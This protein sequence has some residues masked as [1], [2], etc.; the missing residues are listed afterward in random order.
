MKR[1]TRIYIFLLLCVCAGA[2]RRGTLTQAQNVAAG[3]AVRQLDRVRV[4]VSVKSPRNEYDL[5]LDTSRRAVA[6]L[7]PQLPDGPLKQEINGAL[8]AYQDAGQVWAQQDGATQKNKD[9]SAIWAK[10]DLT[11]RLAAASPAPTPT[12]SGG[13]MP[14]PNSGDESGAPV[15]TVG[16]IAPPKL[17][18]EATD[19]AHLLI[20][21]TAE[22]HLN[23]AKELLTKEN[24]IF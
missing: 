24:R 18:A 6:E 3:N 19:I 4:A 12:P 9:L 16:E 13:V 15:F 22:E 2:C 11:K 20:W 23:K 1:H 8:D 10:Y 21:Q 5:V 14:A 17:R 7:L